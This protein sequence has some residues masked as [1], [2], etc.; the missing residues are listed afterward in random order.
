MAYFIGPSEHNKIYIGFVAFG[1]EFRAVGP[2][3]ATRMFVKAGLLAQP[4]AV[5]QVKH[6]PPS[7][8]VQAISGTDT[9]NA[10][11]KPS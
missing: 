7:E 9:Q 11:G 2:G 5:Y 1:G 8:G 10:P 3:L 6:A 4:F